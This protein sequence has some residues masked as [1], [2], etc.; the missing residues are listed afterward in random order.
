MDSGAPTSHTVPPVSV[1]DL[2]ELPFNLLTKFTG[3]YQEDGLGASPEA[4]IECL[5]NLPVESLMDAT[6]AVTRY[7]PYPRQVSVWGPCWKTGS[8][9][10]E[11]P[12]KRLQNDRFLNIPVLMGTNKDEGTLFAIG[13]ALNAPKNDS[14]EYFFE[15]MSNSSILNHE[16][17]DSSVFREVAKLYPNDPQVG[18][19]FGTGNQTFGFPAKF[20]RLAA[21]FGDLH[22]Q[23]PR[24]F[25][26]S[27]TSRRQDTYVYYF[28]GPRNNSSPL[29]SG[30]PHSSEI[31]LIFGSGWYQDLEDDE[32]VVTSQ[33][34]EKMRTYYINFVHDLDPGPDWPLYKPSTRLVMKLDKY[35]SSVIEDDWRLEQLS[36]L[37]SQQALDTFDT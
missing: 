22:Y 6:N 4:S 23:A 37:N 16:A 8:F 11:R 1:Y 27:R 33:L 36:Y 5:R 32:K 10:D 31:Q 35:N 19:P 30:V 20:K 14:D 9:I 2:P 18:S 21:W 28:N 12:S 29:Y 13:A 34:A 3:C 15:Y 26:A 25:W 24:R 7:G 17:V